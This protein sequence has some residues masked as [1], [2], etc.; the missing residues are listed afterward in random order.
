MSMNCLNPN[1]IHPL[2]PLLKP[3]HHPN[4]LTFPPNSNSNSNSNSNPK[5]KWSLQSSTN[6]LGPTPIDSLKPYLHSQW[7]LILPG[8][9]FGAVSVFSLSVI[10]PKAGSLSLSSNFSDAN[11]VASLFALRLAA[12]YL[13]Q[14]LLWQAAF[15]CEFEIRKHVFRSVLQRDLGYFDALSAADVAHRIT[16]EAAHVADTVFSLLNTIVP[17]TLQLSAMAAQMLSISPALSLTSALVIPCVALSI[18]FLGSR[19]QRISKAA[20]LSTA[21]LSAYLNEVLSSILFV[22]ASNMEWS[23]CV[24]FNRLANAD[25]SRQLRKKKMKAFIPQIVQ[26][27]YFGTL[28]VV[29]A[30]S[31]VLSR[32]TF[33]MRSLISFVTSL[34][35]LVEPI[36]DVGKAYNELK[37]GEPAIERLFSLARFSPQV[38]E[39]RDAIAL[40]S[41]EGD[42]KFCDI[43]FQYNDDLPLVLN[44]VDLHIKAGQTVA[45]VGPSGGGK[46]TLAKLLLRLYDPLRGCILIDGHDIQ[47]LQ[48]ESLRSHV[49]LV[50]Q[51][52]I[53]FTGTVAENI[54]YRDLMRGVDLERVKAAAETANADE[55]IR[56]LP[57]GY[58]TSIGARGSTLS[59][60]QKQRL[61]IA[62][63][64]YQNSSIL[65][66]DEA[67]SALDS[68]SELLVREAVER[69]MQNHTVLVIAHRLE[70][71]LMAE[72]V[73]L[74]EDG[75][76]REVERST[77]VNGHGDLKSSSGL[78]I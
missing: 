32:G 56:S 39:K 70:T 35:F 64:L 42:L 10:V 5:Q 20:H 66:M 44:G 2:K 46:T 23:E 60:G 50:S 58:E 57:N 25:L 33:S 40:A 19:L 59:G 55:F 34:V 54:G 17:S 9:A 43:S 6:H 51:D 37:Q 76:L 62:R 78:V 38:L 52:I 75:R 15:N 74:L 45:L 65:I 72:R 3:H 68:R 69:V 22:K 24:R 53:L 16:S 77:L 63:A 12:N 41:V 67:T 71:V 73:L 47:S 29:C 21:A 1:I 49:A 26:A 61:A 36:Q 11:L 48:L 28:F 4:Y 30:G 14:A 8:W 7:A 27:V 31:V 18:T 13:Q